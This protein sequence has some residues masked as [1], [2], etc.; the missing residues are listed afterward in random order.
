ML[1]VKSTTDWKVRMGA[2][3][4]SLPSP[5]YWE[6]CC[7]SLRA[8]SDDCRAPLTGNELYLNGLNSGT[9]PSHAAFANAGNTA[10]Q[11]KIPAKRAR[12]VMPIIGEISTMRSGRGSDLSSSASSAYFIASA[13]PFENPI[14]CSGAEGPAAAA[15]P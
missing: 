8:T 1:T 13:P 7:C 11:P 6:I 5:A 9:M 12:L 14:T 15:P 3:S 2:S 4:P 10:G